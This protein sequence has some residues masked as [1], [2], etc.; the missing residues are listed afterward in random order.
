MVTGHFVLWSRLGRVPKSK[1][2]ARNGTLETIGTDGVFKGSLWKIA[3]T[4]YPIVS[5]RVPF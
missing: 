3:E 4:A 5:L 1:K 2:R